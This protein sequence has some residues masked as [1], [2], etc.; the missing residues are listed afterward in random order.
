[1]KKRMFD[2]SPVRA[3]SVRVGPVRIRHRRDVAR[4][5][6][7]RRH[8]L[9]RDA[10]AV[11]VATRAILPDGSIC[12]RW[13]VEEVDSFLMWGVTN[14]C[15]ARGAEVPS[16]VAPTLDTYLRYL[17]ANKLLDQRSDRLNLLRRAVAENAAELRAAERDLARSAAGRSAHP[18]RGP[19]ARL[20]PVLPIG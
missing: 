20:A 13:G 11:I 9:S 2:M 15:R 16:D 3:H 4:W 14:W 18:S 7:E 5:A 10:L 17:S 8:P 19:R 12:A 1:M 6:L